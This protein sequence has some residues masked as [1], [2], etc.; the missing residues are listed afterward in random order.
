MQNI[1]LAFN[2]KI[3]SSSDNIIKMRLFKSK[4]SSK[5]KIITDNIDHHTFAS[6]VKAGVDT[7][8]LHWKIAPFIVHNYEQMI[9]N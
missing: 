7:I 4:T 9:A 2:S 5:I 6:F 3:S 8:G 1:G